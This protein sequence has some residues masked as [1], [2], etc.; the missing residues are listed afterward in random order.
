MDDMRQLIARASIND[1]RGVAH[2]LHEWEKQNA[3]RLEVEDDWEPTPFPLER[4]L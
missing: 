1:R 4:D 3:R 2:L